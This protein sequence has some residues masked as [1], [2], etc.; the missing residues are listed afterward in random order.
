MRCPCQPPLRFD[1]TDAAFQ[2]I[3]RCIFISPYLV[4]SLSMFGRIFIGKSMRTPWK[5]LVA[6]NISSRTLFG[7]NS[8]FVP[9]DNL[10]NLLKD[11]CRLTRRHWRVKLKVDYM[12]LY[13]LYVATANLRLV[14]LILSATGPGFRF[15]LDPRFP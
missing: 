3:N 6:P 13:L 2:L 5:L 11:R 14:L 1:A 4:G 15:V 9:W 10:S 12:S 8:G 7:I